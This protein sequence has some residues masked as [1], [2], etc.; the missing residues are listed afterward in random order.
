MKLGKFTKTSAERKRYAVDY[1]QWLEAGETITSKV[2]AVAPAGALQVDASA[3]ST[4][5]KSIVLFVYGG[6]SGVNYTVDVKATTSLGQTKEDV[7]LF[8]VKDY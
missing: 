4:D 2:F 1:S 8:S 7:I 6:N 5:G 3:I